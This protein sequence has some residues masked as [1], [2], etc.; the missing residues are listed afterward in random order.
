MNCTDL[1]RRAL[2]GAASLAA[3][4]VAPRRGFAA[5]ADS[6]ATPA[7]RLAYG[8]QHAPRPLPFAAAKYVD[9]FF[10]NLQWDAVAARLKA[11]G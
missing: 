6:S 8:Y 10:A 4:A 1:D 2:L 11:V 7:I 5:G 9:A 3:L